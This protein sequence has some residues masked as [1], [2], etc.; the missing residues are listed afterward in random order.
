M[1]RPKRGGFVARHRHGQA[2]LSQ[3]RQGIA[4]AGQQVGGCG[5]HLGVAL[6]EQ[7]HPFAHMFF[8]EG[9]GDQGFETVTDGLTDRVIGERIVAEAAAGVVEALADRGVGVDQ[10]SVEVEYQ[11]LDVGGKRCGVHEDRLG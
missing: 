1:A 4:D 11:S 6:A 2:P 8:P 10:C 7:A 5:E 9:V 3:G